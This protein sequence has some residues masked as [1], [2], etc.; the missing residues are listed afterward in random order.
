MKRLALI[1]AAVASIA[2]SAVAGDPIELSEAQ[3]EAVQSVVR[4]GLKDPDSARF[5][6]IAAGVIDETGFMVCGYVNA[7]NSFGG[8]V[9]MTVFSGVMVA[10]NNVFIQ[11]T[12]GG[13][14]KVQENIRK[15]CSD[16]GA[17][18]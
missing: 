6:T 12:I 8:Y 5:G 16:H 18:I 17:E 15:I 9:G 11:A 7:R 2:T 3:I 4:D 14:D 13:T 10:K 1:A